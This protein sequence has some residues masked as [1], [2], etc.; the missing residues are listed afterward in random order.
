MHH[1]ARERDGVRISARRLARYDGAAGISQAERLRHL[2]ERLAHR[3]VDGGTERDVIA[4]ATHV[5]EHRV[6]ARHERHHRRRREVRR[7]DLV[8]VQMALEVVHADERHVLRPG[9][10]FRERHA[11]HK[12]AHKARRVGDGHG[13]EIAP[14]QARHAQ[15]GSRRVQAFVAHAADGLDVLAAGDL[16]HHAAEARMEVDLRG[17]DVGH[18]NA[19]AVH[20]GRSRFVAG[21]FD[22]EDERAGRIERRNLAGRMRFECSLA[23]FFSRSGTG[24]ALCIDFAR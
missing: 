17:H 5:H 4:P 18:K 16:R 14:A 22:G 6:A 2:V 7:A 21:R 15:A 13:I 11:H 3:V 1:R 23:Q 24:R 20:D 9:S 10:P 19:L 8:R 12:R